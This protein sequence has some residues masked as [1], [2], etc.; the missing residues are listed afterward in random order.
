M[1]NKLITYKDSLDSI[2][3]D[4]LKGF[5]VGWPEPPSAGKFLNILRQ[6]THVWLA[7]DNDDNKVVGFINSLSDNELTAYIPLLEVL[8]EYQGRGIGKKLVQQMLDTL[9]SIYMIDLVCDKELNSF[10]DKFDFMQYNAMIK[11]NR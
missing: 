10:Y 4:Q 5:F 2:T 3:L 9:K 11:R 7:I 8:P 6:S 1:K